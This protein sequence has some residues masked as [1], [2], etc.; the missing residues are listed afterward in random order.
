MLVVAGVSDA[1]D[2]FI[3]KRFDRRTR[4]GALLDPVA[5]KVLLVSVYVTLGIA[6]Q[7][8]TWLV[9]LV[10]FRDVLIVG[11]FLFVQAI[12]VAETV[13]AAVHQQDQHGRADGPRGLRPRA[14]RPRCGPGL[15][16]FRLEPGSGGD[17]LGVGAGL[18]PAVGAHPRA[19]GANLVNACHPRA[20]VDIFSPM[21]QLLLDLRRPPS[22]A[23]SDFLSSER[24][25]AAVERIDRWPDWPSA[26]LL[27]YGPPGCGKTHLAHL[28]CERASANL[29][30]G[31][32]LTP[33]ALP[34]LIERIRAG[35]RSTMRI[36]LRSGPCSTSIIPASSAGAVS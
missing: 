16:R 31:E 30:A 13:S 21:I 27:L 5:D 17:D 25:V 7:L 23:R 12:D 8:W 15:A 36:A 29:I 33:A 18:P 1:L 22:F 9:V 34:R 26:A 35:S 2:G 3:A 20:A 24:N 4:L 19:L 11:G 6:G 14:A 10:V 28:W 32:N